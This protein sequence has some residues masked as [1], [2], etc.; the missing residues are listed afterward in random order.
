M[1]K[2]REERGGGGGGETEDDGKRRIVTTGHQATD[3]DQGNGMTDIAS[4]PTS[5]QDQ[6]GSHHAK[7]AG[8]DEGEGFKRSK[9]MGK[10]NKRRDQV[11]EETGRSKRQQRENTLRRWDW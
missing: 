3:L 4:G 7:R 10:D 9:V 11:S 6:W 5:S 2:G 8:E 1:R